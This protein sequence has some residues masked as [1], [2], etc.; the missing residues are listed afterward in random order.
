MLTYQMPDTIVEVAMKGEFNEFDLN[1]FF[2]ADGEGSNAKFKYEDY[3]QKWLDLIRGNLAETTID[4]LKMGAKKPPMPFSDTRLLNVLQ[5]TFWFY[6]RSL[7]A[8]Q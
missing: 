4:N 5:H 3:V 2:S 6:Q 8:M 1:V 7:L